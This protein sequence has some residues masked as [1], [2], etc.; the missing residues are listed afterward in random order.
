MKFSFK[1]FFISHLVAFTEEIFIGKLHFFYSAT[2]RDNRAMHGAL[3]LFLALL[4]KTILIVF[5]LNNNFVVYICLI[6]NNINFKSN[7]NLE[8]LFHILM[9]KGGLMMSIFGK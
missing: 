2:P 9:T 1:D 7:L 4:M 8:Q 5:Y 3:R 6:F